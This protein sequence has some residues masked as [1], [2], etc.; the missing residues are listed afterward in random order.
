MHRSL[1]FRAAD[2]ATSRAFPEPPR[3]QEALG[4]PGSSRLNALV[5]VEQ[6]H[7]APN[8]AAIQNG[9]VNGYTAYR[10]ADSVTTHEAWGLGRY[11][12]YNVDPP[13]VQHNGFAATTAPGVKFH[14]LL[15]ISLGGNGQCEHVINDTGA[16]ASGTSTI[17][18]NVVSYPWDATR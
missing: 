12:N 14:G 1:Q 6:A 13:I 18:F 17:P 16:P 8:Q 4:E 11:C 3:A 5:R 15:V 7:D 10:V 2:C 9:S